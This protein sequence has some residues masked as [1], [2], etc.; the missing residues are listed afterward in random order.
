M[1]RRPP[2]P[3]AA[4]SLLV[5][6]LALLPVRPSAAAVSPEKHLKILE[7]VVAKAARS[8]AKY[9]SRTTEGGRLYSEG[10][11]KFNSEDNFHGMLGAAT[12]FYRS[13][14]AAPTG[15]VAHFAWMMGGLSVGRMVEH[16]GQVAPSASS[17]SPSLLSSRLSRRLRKLGV[18]PSDK[19][20]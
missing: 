14:I 5:F 2:L 15:P 10:M 18:R 19:A 17:S 11:A 13:V 16:V 3:F 12:K 6:S 4:F 9:G 7:G 1:A 8:P 20:W